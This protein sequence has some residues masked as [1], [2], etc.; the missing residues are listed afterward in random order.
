MQAAGSLAAPVS[1]LARR[2]GP[3]LERGVERRPHR[4]QSLRHIDAALVERCDE[5]RGQRSRHVRAA[6]A[7]LR[8]AGHRVVGAAVHPVLLDQA[9]RL[10][11]QCIRRH[12]PTGRAR[13]RGGGGHVLRQLLSALSVGEALR[14]AARAA[15][16]RAGRCAAAW[17]RPGA[18]DT[19]RGHARAHAWA[20]ARRATPSARKAGRG[21]QANVRGAVATPEA[22]RARRHLVTGHHAVKV[23]PAAGAIHAARAAAAAPPL[24]AVALLLHLLLPHRVLVH[25]GDLLGALH[26]C[27]RLPAAA[28]HVEHVLHHEPD[29]R[30]E[31]RV[32]GEL[33]HAL[34]VDPHVILVIL[35][36]SGVEAAA[37][38]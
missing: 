13:G 38:R 15:V 11:P 14:G 23:A 21:T 6:I 31:A 37:N 16:R 18:A 25:L 24:L 2:Q 10:L 7:E 35:P 1:E 29:A 33:G 8:E 17:P 3:R 27:A 22:E 4:R 30:L 36:G 26:L 32:F 12:G 28:A 19:A 20:C 5:E 34:K 9:C